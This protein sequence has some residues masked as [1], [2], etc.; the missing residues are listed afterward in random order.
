MQMEPV[1]QSVSLVQSLVQYPDGQSMRQRVLPLHGLVREQAWPT[2]PELLGALEQMPALQVCVGVQRRSHAPQ[3]AASVLRLTQAVPHIVCGA[4]QVT[5]LRQTPDTQLC[6]L[7]QRVPHA[8]QL[9][10][11]VLRLTQVVPHIVCGNAQPLWQRPAAHVSPS[12]HD[13]LQPPQC[14]GLMLVS[15][16]PPPHAS[17]GAEHP[18]E[19]T[20]TAET[21]RAPTEGLPSFPTAA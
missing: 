12:A 8:P 10:E 6:A 3:L 18:T 1:S 9:A 7:V 13:W 16:Q 2:A 21:S 15:T 19:P 5:V 20:S 17:R 11:S 14:A 4:E